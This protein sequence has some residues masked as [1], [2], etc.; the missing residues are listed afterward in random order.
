MD[1]LYVFLLFDLLTQDMVK[2][3]LIIFLKQSLVNSK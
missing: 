3:N 2:P 1:V